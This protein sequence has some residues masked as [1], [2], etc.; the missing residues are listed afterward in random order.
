MDRRFIKF[1]KSIWGCI[2]TKFRIFNPIS[3]DFELFQTKE[4]AELRLSVI[5]MEYIQQEDY[6]FS[7]AKEIIDG[8]NTTWTL[9]DLNNDLENYVYQVFNH[10]TG[11][12]EAVASLSQAKIRN[13]EL[14]NAFLDDVFASAIIEYT[15]PQSIPSTII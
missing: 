6:R 5:K 15:E 13:Q 9:A 12:H 3:N 1:I 2:M 4:E 7:V 11:Q 10:S 8:N 14:K